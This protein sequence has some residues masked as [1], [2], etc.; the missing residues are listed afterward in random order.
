MYTTKNIKHKKIKQESGYKKN[1]ESLPHKPN[2]YTIRKQLSIKMFK[3]SSLFFNLFVIFVA[4]KLNLKLTEK[5]EN[6]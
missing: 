3:N 5:N 4:Y 6:N 2:A 1:V